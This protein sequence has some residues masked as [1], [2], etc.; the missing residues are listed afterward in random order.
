[1]DVLCS[2]IALGL[3]QILS[4]HMSDRLNIQSIRYLRTYSSSVASEATMTTF[5]RRR[6]YLLFSQPDAL[7]VTRMIYSKQFHTSKLKE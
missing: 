1:M 3:L 7:K 2:Q 4:L 5:I 6:I